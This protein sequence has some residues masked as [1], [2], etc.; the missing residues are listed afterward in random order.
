MATETEVLQ[1][2]IRE[3]AEFTRNLGEEVAHQPNAEK[4]RPAVE[5]SLSGECVQC[6][7]RVTGSELLKISN[8]ETAADTKLERLRSG[9]CARN[10]CDS[11]FYRVMCAPH[12][13]V[14]WP[15]L[16]HREREI[17][18]T[19]VEEQKVKVDL[20]RT[21]RRYR[22][23]LRTATIIG[24]LFVVI[25]LRQIYV[26]GSIPFVREP[27]AFKVDRGVATDGR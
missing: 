23:L 2:T 14:D 13:L 18:Q 11:N 12:P 21:A 8:E 17:T 25:I 24:V 9:Y 1:M 20:A 22:N 16:L 19:K 6:S 10:G 5:E 4:L 15:K 27:E 3:L 26:G 7:I